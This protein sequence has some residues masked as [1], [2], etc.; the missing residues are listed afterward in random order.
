MKNDNINRIFKKLVKEKPDLEPQDFMVYAIEYALNNPDKIPEL[1]EANKEAYDLFA[2]LNEGELL[3]EELPLLMNPVMREVI[4][5]V[6][7]K[8]LKRSK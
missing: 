5:Y 4:R 2:R 8:L 3:V 6:C 1:M 7:K